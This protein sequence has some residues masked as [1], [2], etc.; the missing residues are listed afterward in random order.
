MCFHLRRYESDTRQF[1]KH[2][3]SF[4]YYTA[5]T[6]HTSNMAAATT[7]DG[8]TSLS[9]HRQLDSTD[10]YIM[11]LARS[12]GVV[13][14]RSAVKMT[15]LACIGHQERMG[16]GGR[17]ATHAAP[18]AGPSPSRSPPVRPGYSGATRRLYETPSLTYRSQSCPTL[19]NL[20]IG[21]SIIIKDRA[22]LIFRPILRNT[23]SA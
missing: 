13:G 20:K 4:L 6:Q 7:V 5:A 23:T 11:S 22:P 21:V 18:A 19:W 9:P 10:S 8:M 12:T 2:E 16:D 17:Q 3:S 14:R 15:A 1:C